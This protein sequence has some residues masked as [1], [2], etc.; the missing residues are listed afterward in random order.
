[1]SCTSCRLFI[2]QWGAHLSPIM[3][4]DLCHT[5]LFLLAAQILGKR[6]EGGRESIKIAGWQCYSREETMLMVR[7]I[8]LFF[9]GGGEGGEFTHFLAHPQESCTWTRCSENAA[10]AATAA[11]W[12]RP[13]ALGWNGTAAP[14]NTEV[15]I[16]YEQRE[17]TTS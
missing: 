2:E 4:L 14:F 1:M 15:L 12:P 9:W 8:S 5:G 13:A 3:A 17:T 10:A 7:M 11:P 6:R 16:S